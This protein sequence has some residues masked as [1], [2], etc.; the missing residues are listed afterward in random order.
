MMLSFRGPAE[1]GSQGGLRRRGGPSCAVD[2]AGVAKLLRATFEVVD[3]TDGRSIGVV[4]AP[5]LICK[6][7]FDQLF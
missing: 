7:R 4:P 6:H 3:A 1:A 5:P 2:A